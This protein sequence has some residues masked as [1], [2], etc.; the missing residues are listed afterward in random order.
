MVAKLAV[1][2]HGMKYGSIF[3]IIL[4]LTGLYFLYKLVL[5]EIAS[6]LIQKSF[7][8]LSDIP[9]TESSGSTSP[10]VPGSTDSSADSVVPAVSN[11]NVVA[12]VDPVVTTPAPTQP[13]VKGEQCGTDAGAFCPDTCPYCCYSGGQDKYYCTAQTSGLVQNCFQSQCGTPSAAAST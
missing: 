12:P 5:F 1:K 13:V 7:E 11:A 9:A 2:S 8:V 10:T 3:F 4:F 6:N